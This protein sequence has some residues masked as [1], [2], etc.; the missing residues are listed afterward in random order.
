MDPKKIRDLLEKYYN[1]ESTLE[2][3]SLL[4]EYF[5]N[6]PVDQEFIADQD[7]FLY[8]D[9]E[10]NHTEDIP[11]ISEELWHE[12]Q[13]KSTHK[14]NSNNKIGYFYLRIA[15]SIII[16]IGS[17]FLIKNQVFNKNTE[18][19]FTDT[20]DNPDLAYQQAKE[21]LL[22]VSEMLNTGKDHLEPIKKIEEGTQPLSKLTSFNK[23]LNE[24]K[25]IT[26]YTKADKYFKQ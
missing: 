22:Y 7:I 19:Q 16:I 18:I 20:Y 6:E 23:G 11:D 8:Q 9:Q 2:E 3:E 26:E 15:A 25:P 5:L 24:L 13:N 14:V 12:L 1:G 4:R 10:T 21:T 17:F